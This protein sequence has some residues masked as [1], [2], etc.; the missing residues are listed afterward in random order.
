ILDARAHGPF[1]SLSDFLSRVDLSKVNKKT[2]ESLI[3]AGALDVFGRRRALLSSYPDVV[4]KASRAQKDIARNQASLFGDPEPTAKEASSSTISDM[5]EFSEREMLMF[6]KELLGFFL[7]NHPLNQE[8]E[9]LA[10]FI[11]HNISDLEEEREET[12]LKIGGLVSSVKKII[13]KKSNQEMAFVTV[14][15]IAGISIEC[16]VFPKTYENT[17]NVLLRD[18]I[19]IVEGRLQFKDD[20]PVVIVET[21]RRLA[22]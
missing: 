8:L 14:E 11:T 19:V 22:S 12:V 6:E 17:K 16:V 9:N 20:R 21:V 13:T 3:K 4:E 5:E 1:T 2:M 7:T 18:A 15:D 10:R